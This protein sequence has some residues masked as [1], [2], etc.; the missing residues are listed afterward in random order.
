MND[1]LLF[2]YEYIYFKDTLFISH[3]EKNFFIQRYT[4]TLKDNSYK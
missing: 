3:F 1:V 2:I 4:N